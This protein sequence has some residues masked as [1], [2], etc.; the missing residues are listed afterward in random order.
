MRLLVVAAVVAVDGPATEVAVV[1]GAVVSGAPP[2]GVASE[3][4][5][6]GAV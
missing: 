4:A 1:D 3:A 2:E 5:G 6:V